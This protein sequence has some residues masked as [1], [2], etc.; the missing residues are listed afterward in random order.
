MGIIGCVEYA[1]FPLI[2][3]RTNGANGPK[4]KWGVCI[5]QGISPFS[6]L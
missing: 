6:L 1:D 4:P 2:R 3:G 5:T